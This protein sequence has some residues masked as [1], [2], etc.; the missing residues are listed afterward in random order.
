M[1][2]K[3][4]FRIWGQYDSEAFGRAVASVVSGTASRSRNNAHVW[5]SP[6]IV[7]GSSDGEAELRHLCAL[8]R[9]ALEKQLPGGS[10]RIDLV[11]ARQP[12]MD[13][14]LCG[15]YFPADIVGSLSRMGAGIDYDIVSLL[16]ISG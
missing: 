13:A 14:D 10:S 3:C 5:K 8:M 9:L 12:E 16:D 2:A 7:I 4:Y 11:I 1:R 6:E 15:M